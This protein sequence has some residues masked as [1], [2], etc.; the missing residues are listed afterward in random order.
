[1]N[2]TLTRQETK[3]ITE[4][5][6]FQKKR[7]NILESLCA[8][9]SDQECKI[10]FRTSIHQE[11]S[12]SYA[13]I[14][15]GAKAVARHFLKM[16]IPSKSRV[17]IILPTCVEFQY[18]FYGAMLAGCIPVPVAPVSFG[19][20]DAEYYNNRLSSVINNSD[21]HHII[22]FERDINTL[23][24]RL[25]F[26]P[27]DINFTCL[28]HIEFTSSDG[29]DYCRPQLD[30]I[31]FIQYTSG[32][33]GSEPKGVPLTHRNVLANLEGM[34][35][36]QD[37]GPSDKI[38]SWMPLYHD[39]GLLGAMLLSVHYSLKK[40]ILIAPIMIARPIIWL[41]YITDHQMTLT[42]GNNFSYRLCVKKISD[43]DTSTLNL[44]SLRLAFNGSEPIDVGVIEEFN[45]KFGPVGFKKAAMMPCYGLAEATLG[46]TFS[47]VLEEP[48]ILEVDSG[49]LSYGSTVKP[50]LSKDALQNTVKLVALG[51]P[52]FCLQVKILDYQGKTLPDMVV[53]KIYISGDSVMNGY[54]V[55]GG[56]DRSRFEGDW[57][58]TGDLGFLYDGNLYFTGRE[59][60]LIIIRGE[61]YS[62]IDIENVV[63]STENIDFDYNSIACSINMDHGE[64]LAILIETKETLQEKLQSLMDVV[65]L[66]LLECMGIKASRI[67]IVPPKSIPLTLNGKIRRRECSN[68]FRADSCNTYDYLFAE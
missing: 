59:K 46:V 62:A 60:E 49:Q 24:D 36:A 3:A 9:A 43:K 51:S 17:I 48:K 50:I 27:V 44:E 12:Y 61:N 16:G 15:E 67:S 35:A 32:S 63:N 31:C 55:D 57:F 41:K 10:I 47:P 40:L 6:K 33:T 2:D 42:L 30:D 52:L 65:Q 29:F 18:C 22:S 39:M 28:E 19:T 53:G 25:G 34:G 23:T 56:Y 20:Q 1:M 64:S 38:V 14:L 7:Q 8:S 45:A 4:I 37:M 11:N 54:Y 13:D 21:C 5:S 26:K 68:F 66:R 58:F